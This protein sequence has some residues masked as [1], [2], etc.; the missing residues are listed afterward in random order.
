MENNEKTNTGFVS[1]FRRRIKRNLSCQ[2]WHFTALLQHQLKPSLLEVPSTN[3]EEAGFMTESLSVYRLWSFAGSWHRFCSARCIGSSRCMWNRPHRRTLYR[4]W[5][6][7]SEPPAGDNL[8]HR[9]TEAI[10]DLSL[11]KSKILFLEMQKNSCRMTPGYLV[12]SRWSSGRSCRIKPETVE[13]NLLSCVR[14]VRTL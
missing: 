3:M 6:C 5:G 12:C 13:F 7:S 14:S 11:N 9:E 1:E 4:T 10:A 2:S 8:I